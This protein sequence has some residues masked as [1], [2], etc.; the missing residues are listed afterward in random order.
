MAEQELKIYAKDSV[1]DST[2]GNT[3][4]RE[5]TDEEFLQGVQR[6]G[7]VSTQL[8]NSLLSLVTH[9][10]PPSDTSPYLHKSSQPIPSIALEMNGQATP[11]DSILRDFYGTN[12]DDLTGDAPTGYTYIVR[13]H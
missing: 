8:W 11:V 12:L 13:N 1:I 3:Q 7:G 5:I 4:K 6:L 10:S 9:Y 2:K